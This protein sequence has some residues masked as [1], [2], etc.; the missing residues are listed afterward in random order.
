MQDVENEKQRH[1]RFIK[2]VCETGSVWGLENDE[3]FAMSSSEEYEDADGEAVDLM[4]FWSEKSLAQACEK[5]E[6]VGYRTTEI[7]LGDFMENWCIG[8]YEDELLIGTDLDEEL[9]GSEIDPLDLILELCAELKSQGK[10]IQFENYKNIN[11]LVKEIE[12]FKSEE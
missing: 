7:A 11:D 6:W 8:M 4:C 9:F 10:E 1:K 5:K 3:G 2:K 12:T